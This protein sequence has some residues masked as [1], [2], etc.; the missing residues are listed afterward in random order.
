[1]KVGDFMFSWLTE[2]KKF[3]IASQMNHVKSKQNPADEASR[4]V[5]SQE[6]LH[7]HWINGPAFL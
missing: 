7:S 5:K 6:L 3:K 2:F 1:M 4:G